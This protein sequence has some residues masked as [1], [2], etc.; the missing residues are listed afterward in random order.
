M[1]RRS[2]TF[3]SLISVLTGISHFDNI[4]KKSGIDFQLTSGSSSKPYILESMGGGVGFI[5]YNNDGWID[6]Y[7]VNGSTLEAEQQKHY[8]GSNRL[9]RNNGDGT[10][11]DVSEKARAAGNGHWGMG[12]CIGD[13][14]ND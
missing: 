1:Y 3:V 9:Y 6:I 2:L 11:T 13:V 8:I 7:L 5:D 14:N 4:T 10:F 12:A